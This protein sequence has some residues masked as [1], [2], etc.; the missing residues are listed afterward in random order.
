MN[1]IGRE[2]GVFVCDWFT[3][4]ITGVLWSWFKR[5]NPQAKTPSTPSRG[6]LPVGY[7]LHKM[8]GSKVIACENKLIGQA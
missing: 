1:L 5:D 6:F 7:P 3:H 2:D 8:L 4:L